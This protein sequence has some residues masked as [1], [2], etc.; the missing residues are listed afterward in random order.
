MA[1]LVKPFLLPFPFPE[2]KW[3]FLSPSEAIKKEGGG[4]TD[5]TGKGERKKEKKRPPTFERVFY[6]IPR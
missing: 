5:E 1:D 4:K 2:R 3:P 6:W